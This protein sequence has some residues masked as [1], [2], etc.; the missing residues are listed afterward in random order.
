MALSR[1][2]PAETREGTVTVASPLLREQAVSDQRAEGG[3]HGHGAVGAS[4]LPTPAPLSLAV[5]LSGDPG[6][7]PE[8]G[9]IPGTSPRL[10]CHRDSQ[11]EDLV[12]QQLKAPNLLPRLLGLA[13]Q[14]IACHLHVAVHPRRAAVHL[15]LHGHH[16]AGDRRGVRKPRGRPC[17]LPQPH[18]PRHCPLRVTRLTIESNCFWEG[19]Q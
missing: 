18:T 2:V 1:D 4:L 14:P 16:W 17:P 19:G 7:H 9:A 13:G 8:S 10:G 15:G 11:D 5:S 3:G 12:P 6:V